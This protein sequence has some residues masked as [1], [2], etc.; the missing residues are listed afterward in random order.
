MLIGTERSIARFLAAA[1]RRRRNP[2]IQTSTV[3]ASSSKKGRTPALRLDACERRVYRLALLLTG[4]PP[5]AIDVVESVV[6]DGRDLG[7]MD[8][9]RLDRLTLLRARERVAGRTGPVRG[10]WA[11]PAVG[12]T[13]S[14]TLACLRP[15]QREAWVLSRVYRLPER[16]MARSM[17]CS[18]TAA[19]RHL[20]QAD[21]VVSG[22]LGERA[23][24]VADELLH[25]SL[26][27]DVPA[28]YRA[29]RVR[30]RRIRRA[31]RTAAVVLAAAAVVA[32][33]VWMILYTRPAGGE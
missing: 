3:M 22:R 9:A 29:R 5:A 17:D 32:L 14:E 23:A 33:A 11:D 8:S 25:V 27:V 13:V 28:I 7:K 15:Q 16:E 10:A 12:R 30:R 6:S 1:K 21:T 18:L 26:A 4:G 2:G 31:V 20:E 24:T 19:R